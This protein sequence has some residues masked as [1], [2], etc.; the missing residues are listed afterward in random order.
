M[1]SG[2]TEIAAI[3]VYCAT[4][5]FVCWFVI[6]HLAS[7]EHDISARELLLLALQLYTLHV[8]SQLL[9]IKKSSEECNQTGRLKNDRLEVS[10]EKHRSQLMIWAT[11]L[12]S[13]THLLEQVFYANRQMQ[14]EICQLQ[15]AVKK[16]LL[17]KKEAANIVYD[18]YAARIEHAAWLKALVLLAALPTFL[19]I[20]Y[21]FIAGFP[22]DYEILC[23]TIAAVAVVF[24]FAV[25]DGKGHRY[26]ASWTKKQKNFYRVRSLQDVKTLLGE[27]EA[28][29]ISEEALLG[30]KPGRRIS[31]LVMD[32]VRTLNLELQ[33]IGKRDQ[34]EP[35]QLTISLMIGDKLWLGLQRLRLGV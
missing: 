26:T 15:R 13:Q 11:A 24:A 18:I 6:G 25:I 29:K 10:L 21:F 17:E 9:C 8:I 7:A 1:A 28:C 12:R 27:D 14:N 19:P 2:Y 31:D 34:D 3:F 23:S 22:T 32:D 33:N 35:R 20:V 30:G 5:I 16:A 4:A